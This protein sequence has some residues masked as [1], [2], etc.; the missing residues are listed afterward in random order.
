MTSYTYSRMSFSYHH[1]NISQLLS[2]CF[3]NN[4]GEPTLHVHTSGK[5]W[6]EGEEFI[7]VFW[8]PNMHQ[9][10]LYIKYTIDVSTGSCAENDL[11]IRK[12]NIM[13]INTMNWI[14]LLWVLLRKLTQCKTPFCGLPTEAFTLEEGI[15]CARQSLRIMHFS[16]VTE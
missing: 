9:E 12:M 4:S 10:D 8:G 14:T 11:N 2:N 6:H 3:P 7:D 16:H 13:I 1:S 5:L 15:G